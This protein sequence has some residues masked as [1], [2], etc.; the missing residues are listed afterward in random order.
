MKTRAKA[1]TYCSRNQSNKCDGDDTIGPALEFS[2]KTHHLMSE[3]VGV[4]F[5]NEGPDNSHEHG[6]KVGISLLRLIL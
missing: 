5:K 4:L 2:L 1:M 6:M 3:K